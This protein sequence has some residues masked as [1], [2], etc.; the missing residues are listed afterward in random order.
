M[1]IGNRAVVNLATDRGWY[2]RGQRRLVS[3]VTDVGGVGHVIHMQDEAE[4]YAPPH[5]EVSYAF[6]PHAIA[7]AAAH[8]GADVILWADASVYAIRDLEPVFDHIEDHGH[9]FFYNCGAGQ[10]SSGHALNFFG[11]TREESF[12]IPMLMGLCMGLDLR[13]ER[14]REFLRRWLH[15]IP[16]FAG[17]W[18]NANGE[19]SKDPRVTGHRH[20]QTAASLIAHQLQM[21]MVIPHQTF[22]HC[23]DWSPVEDPTHDPR[24]AESVC[25][26]AQGM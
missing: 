16:M 3:T 10:W 26:L 15:S 6:K 23:P 8:L 14:P 5:S 21:D 17:S 4:C 20:D 22:L 19:V 13:Q 1:T 24:I 7:V 9:L 12:Q 18:T 2:R 25:L 11:V